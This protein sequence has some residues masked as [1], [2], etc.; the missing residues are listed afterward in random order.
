MA[1]TK[2][3]KASADYAIGRGKPPPHTRF[4]PGQSGNPGGRKKGSLNLKTVLE[5]VSASEIEVTE[6]GRKRKVPR[7]EAMIMK[8]FQIGLNGDM[9]AIKDLLDRCERLGG[10]E[11]SREEELPE[12]DKLILQRMLAL[13]GAVTS[14]DQEPS[15]NRSPACGVVQDYEV[16]RDQEEEED[17][18]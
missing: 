18:E 14:R 11:P 1:K 10:S 16:A 17:D 12:E 6:N 3:V 5:T 2:K 15:S 4:R 9:R 13:Q 7:I 8:A